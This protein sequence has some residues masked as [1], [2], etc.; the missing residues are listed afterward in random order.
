MT[1][2]FPLGL[3]AVGPEVLSLRSSVLTTLDL[4]RTRRT[5]VSTESDQ[6]SIRREWVEDVRDVLR[7]QV[8][9]PAPR[10]TP[11]NL[12]HW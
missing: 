8:Q 11:L 5:D 6:L 2:P 4:D 10:H 9:L 3:T 1:G 7:R 12:R